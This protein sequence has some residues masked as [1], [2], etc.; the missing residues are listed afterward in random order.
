MENFRRF[1][2]GPDPF[3]KTW[4]VEFRWQQNGISIRHA[5]T[6]DVK[7]QLFVDGDTHE[8]IIALT[9]PA[10]LA[11]SRELGRPLT[12]AWVMKIS[13]LHLRQMILTD[14]DMDKDLVTLD[15]AEIRRHAAELE[16]LTPAAV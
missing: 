11:V 15:A 9:H 2:A 10:L 16:R 4:T 5:D 1:E 14:E 3:D 8:K 7:F 12:D 6:V 13:A